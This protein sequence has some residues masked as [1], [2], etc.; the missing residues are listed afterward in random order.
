MGSES[1]LGRTCLGPA[2]VRL[3][4]AIAGSGNN[5]KDGTERGPLPEVYATCLHR[6]VLP[7]NPWLADH[8]ISRALRHRNG[9]MGPSGSLALSADHAAAEA[10]AAALRLACRPARRWGGRGRGRLGETAWLGAG[11]SQREG[12]RDGVLAERRAA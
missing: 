9:D 2:A 5:G 7:E 11:L 4:W 3:G 1:H 6:P 8:L 10:R 12:E